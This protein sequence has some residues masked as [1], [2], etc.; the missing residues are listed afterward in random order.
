VAGE[1]Y[2]NVGFWSTVPILPGAADGDVNRTV[3]RVVAEHGGHKSLYSD[4]YYDEENFRALYGGAAYEAVKTRY[5]PD[6][7]LLDLYAKAVM[8]R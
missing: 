8:R 6:G 3:E 4:A 7:R 2:V 5:D 1:A